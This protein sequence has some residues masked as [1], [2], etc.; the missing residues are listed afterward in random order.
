MC[1]DW[2]IEKGL[3][4]CALKEIQSVDSFIVTYAYSHR[5]CQLELR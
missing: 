2:S 5:I 3:M 1:E 4:R